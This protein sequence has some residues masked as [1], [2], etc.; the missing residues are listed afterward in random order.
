[1]KRSL[2]YLGSTV[3]LLA[4]I[5]CG[6]D[7]EQRE[8]DSTSGAATDD[9]DASDDATES[10]ATD[11]SDDAT[12]VDPGTDA[13]GESD[14]AVRDTDDS[15]A[16]DGDPSDGGS[17]GDTVVLMDDEGGSSIE[18]TFTDDGVQCG[19]ER[20]RNARLE[21]VL[22]V[23]VQSCCFDETESICG[24]DMT[25]LG[26]ALSLRDPGCER[27][28]APGNPDSSCPESEPVQ[29]LLPSAP[30][31]GVVMDGCCQANGQ[32]GYSAEFGEFGFGCVEPERFDQES[33]GSCTP[34]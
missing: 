21:G 3:V 18:I 29:I 7:D 14:A 33:A 28:D 31:D 6:D 34:E 22:P 8:T 12:D 30:Q 23:G 5:G 27:L 15:S 13:A 24:F 4:F 9:S 1:M 32:C 20:C 10:D 16:T 26:L 19:A 2:A 17:D 11:A 25:V